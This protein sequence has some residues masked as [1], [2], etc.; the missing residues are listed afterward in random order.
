MF[1]QLKNQFKLCR[2]VMSELKMFLARLRLRNR[3]YV[4]CVWL[5]HLPV[6]FAVCEFGLFINTVSIFLNCESGVN[7]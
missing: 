6:G 2:T 7:S 4:P 5:S 3:L 1:D